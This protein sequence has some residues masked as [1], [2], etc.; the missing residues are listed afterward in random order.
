M[1]TYLEVN[2]FSIAFTQ[3]TGIDYHTY[4]GEFFINRNELAKLNDLKTSPQQVITYGEELLNNRASINPYGP[5]VLPHLVG[6]ALEMGDVPLALDYFNKLEP[7]LFNPNDY[8]YYAADFHEAGET[9]F[10]QQLV[11]QARINAA[12]YYFDI[13]EF[14]RE[15]DKKFE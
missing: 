15:V 2:D 5:F 10:A 1:S 13:E 6:A 12:K 3:V 8:L 7:M 11:E 14:E 4:Y 9:K